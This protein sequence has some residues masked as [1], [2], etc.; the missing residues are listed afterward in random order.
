M[1]LAT[2]DCCGAS[3]H[4]ITVQDGPS[5]LT[6][7]RCGQCSQQ[8]RTIDGIP[9]EREEAFTYLSGAYREIPQAA[10]EVRA[11]A[12]VDREAWRLAREARRTA[13]TEIRLDELDEPVSH[14]LIELLSGCQVLG[15]AGWWWPTC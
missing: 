5:T 14:E 2:M 10:Q 4:E 12:A 8:A 3:H 1:G 13:S 15:A 7:M 9:V 11:G 6:L